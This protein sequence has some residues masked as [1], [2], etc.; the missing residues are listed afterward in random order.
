[1]SISSRQIALLHVGRKKLGWSEAAWRSALAELGG[2]T[3]VTEL[4]RE[5]FDLIL[6]FMEWR[7]FAPMEA[8]GPDFGARPG[9]AS[10]AQLELIRTLWRE[11]TRGEGTA[12]GLQ[13]WLKKCW[14]VEHQRFL[15]AGDARKAIAAL[16][17]MKARAA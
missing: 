2:V 6:G 15:T 11:W 5:G 12:E 13:A 8:K 1:M 4:D 17:A 10:F 14:K 7:G 16:K 9:F 3:S